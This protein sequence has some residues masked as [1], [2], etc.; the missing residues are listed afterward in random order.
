MGRTIMEDTAPAS[1]SAPILFW[2]ISIISLLWNAYGGY[3]YIMTNLRDP[4]F[5]KM[6]P[7][8]MMPYMETLPAWTT[9]A[10][11]FGVWGSI[12]GSLLLLVRSRHAVTA[13]LISLIGA[14]VSFG[15]QYANH[16]PASMTSSG[17]LAMTAMIFAA[18]IVFWWYARRSAANGILR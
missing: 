15:Y 13:F 6:M 17:G 11:A 16:P 5:L 2:A 14:V 10:W 3:D 7:A 1:K 12:A 4:G 8:D 18:I 9:G